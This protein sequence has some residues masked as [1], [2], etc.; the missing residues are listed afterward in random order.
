ML[1]VVVRDLVTSYPDE[2]QL[3]QSDNQGVWQTDEPKH[4]Y[5]NPKK[6][7]ELTKIQRCLTSFH[8]L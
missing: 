3:V 2:V 5:H 1:Y 7:G 4:F 6:Y 8:Q